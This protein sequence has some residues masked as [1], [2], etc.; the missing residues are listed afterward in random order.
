MRGVG[1]SDATKPI[2]ID[3]YS[4][5]SNNVDIQYLDTTN[6]FK[7]WS[8]DF[9]K[10][11]WLRYNDVDFSK[12][13]GKQVTLMVKTDGKATLAVRVGSATAAPLAVAKIKKRI[14]WCEVP[15]KIK[16][17]PTGKQDIFVTCEEGTASVDW[18]QFK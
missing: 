3:R 14:P 1:I 13:T 2:Q 9:Q 17:V 8:A 4:D 5:K 6:Y 18:V 11:S 7:G 16:N 15:V 10:G 12:A